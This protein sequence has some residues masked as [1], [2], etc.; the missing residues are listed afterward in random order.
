MAPVRGRPFLDYLLSWLRSEGVQEVILCVGYKRSHIQ[1]FVGKGR[2]WGLRV[3]YSV[4]QELLGTGGAMK[5][6]ARLTSRRT[7]LVVNGDTFVDV[8]L[9]ELM[10]F[11]R[12]MGALATLTSVRV[13]DSGRYGAL[14]LDGK[15]RVTAFL[16]KSGRVRRSKGKKPLIN[17][18]IYVVERK[19]LKNIRTNSPV[20]FEKEVLPSLLPKRT[21]LGFASDAYFLDIGVPQ[22]LRR[23][24]RELPE[25]I[26]INH[27]R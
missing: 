18:G 17:G 22:D 20:S 23:A 25:R 26:R 27:T 24:Q 8:K 12:R 9:E 11:H 2:K 15:G 5:K 21:V 13:A 6:A 3:Q 14:W 19:A 4:E 1:R 7:M 16:E 10:R